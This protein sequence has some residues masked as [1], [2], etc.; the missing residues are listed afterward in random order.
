MSTAILCLAAFIFGAVAMGFTR[1]A[2]FDSMSKKLEAAES[3]VENARADIAKYE[4]SIWQ[5]D[6]E[7][8]ELL[9]ELACNRR[10]LFVVKTG[11]DEPTEAA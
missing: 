3:Y 11:G 10:G 7:I 8:T 2:R 5:R 4:R 6:D 1:S 9:A